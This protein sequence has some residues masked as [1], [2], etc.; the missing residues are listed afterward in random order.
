[1]RK[2]VL[3]G[4]TGVLMVVGLLPGVVPWAQVQ[5]VAAPVV[6]PFDFDGDGYADLAVGVP[7]EDLGG[8]R[9]AGVVQV[10]Y[11][12]AAGPTARDQM[13]HQNRAGIKGTAEC[14][15]RFGEALASGDFDADG[16]ADLAV[17]V[18]GED[19]G[20]ARDVGIVQVL[21]GGPRGLTARDQLWHQN[22][23]GVPGGNQ[24]GDGF[25]THLAVG[26][27]DAD[28]FADLAIGVPGED[29]SGF[30]D[31]G[32]VVVLRGSASGLTAAGAQKW[33]ESTAGIAHDPADREFFGS[34]L[35]AGDV[36]GDGR[37]DLAIATRRGTPGSQL[38]VGIHVLPGSTGG[39]TATGSQFLSDA[40]ELT[41]DCAEDPCGVPFGDMVLADFNADGRD[42]LGH[43]VIPGRVVVRFARDAGFGSDPARAIDVET[44]GVD[45]AWSISPD[46]GLI[47]EGGEMDLVGTALAAGDLTGDGIADLAIGAPGWGDGQVDVGTVFVVPGS[48][49]V[50]P[51]NVGQQAQ[52]VDPGDRFGAA[53]AILPMGSAAGWLAMGAPGD[54]VSR[55]PRAGS[56]TLCLGSA[57]PNVGACSIWHQNTPGVRGTAETGDGFSASLGG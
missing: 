8:V 19:L 18:P 6:L 22:R 45:Q 39:L 44:P 25:G 53:L 5:A 13:W 46:G 16:Y 17:G 9:D 56:A 14:G 34:A 54:P 21:Y 23:A 50:M 7:G 30:R 35:A 48:R 15:D 3:A 33:D 52:G 36:G 31:A 47:Q 4:P 2:R 20:S 12:S 29:H 57:T 51:P 40:P 32:R 43:A 26:H 24:S 27:F 41:R 11:G 42:D 1:M 10:L 38:R 28:G 37:D 49:T 55:R